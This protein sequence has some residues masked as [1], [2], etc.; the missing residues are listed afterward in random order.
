MGDTPASIVREIAHREARIEDVEVL[1]VELKGQGAH[2]L[3]RVVIDRK[4]GVPIDV[5]QRISQRLS[6][7]LDVADPIGGRYTLE[8]TSPGVDWPLGDRA[9]FDRVEGR[10]VLIHKRGAGD[11]V[12]Q[13]RGRVVRARQDVVELNH[14]GGTVPVAYDD[15]IK[16][17]Q[18]VPW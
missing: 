11:R 10:E 8:V 5:C 14:K 16:A 18:T 1:A 6:Q 4:G 13:I 12:E 7:Q 17:A 3:V 2:R 15:I 9:A